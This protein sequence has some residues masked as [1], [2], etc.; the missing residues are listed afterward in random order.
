VGLAQ[1]RT[2]AGARSDGVRRECRI[3]RRGHARA[4]YEDTWMQAVYT[5]M[6]AR[7]RGSGSACRL[8]SLAVDE[9]GR[10][11]AWGFRSRYTG[12]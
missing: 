11:L 8:I 6:R 7:G 5:T 10:S 3:V 2:R 1:G 4:T 9:H 12:S